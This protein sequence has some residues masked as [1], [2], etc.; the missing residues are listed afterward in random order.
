MIPPS[1]P[2]D[3]SVWSGR[4][5][6]VTG[7]RVRIGADGCES[8][9][10]TLQLIEDNGVVRAIDIACSCGHAFRVVLEY[11]APSNQGSES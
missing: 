10:P 3:R 4:Q 11:P 9:E 1:Q 2:R 6:S 8:V 5:V 7:Q